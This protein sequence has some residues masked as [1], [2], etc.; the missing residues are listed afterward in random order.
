MTLIE[1]LFSKSLKAR[2]NFSNCQKDL[3]PGLQGLLAQIPWAIHRVRECESQ[4]NKP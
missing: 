2:R 3:Q 1:A 4:A